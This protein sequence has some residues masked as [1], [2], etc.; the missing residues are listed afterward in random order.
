MR[1]SRQDRTR[2]RRVVGAVSA[3]GA[4]MLA[5][6][7]STPPGSRLFYATTLGAAGT[8]TIGGFASGPLH[9]GWTSGHGGSGHGASLHRPVVTPV[10]TG[11]AA[12]GCFYAGALVVR[13]VPLLDRALRNVLRFAEEGAQPLV[14]LT[15][16]ANGVAEEVFFRGAVYAA[17]GERH[18]VASSTALYTV[19]TAAT[20]NPALVLAAA[21]MGTLF[22]L[23][24]RASGG[25]QAPI[26]THLTWA[27]LMVRYLPTVIRVSPTPA[28]AV[29]K[30]LR[31]RPRFERL[32]PARVE[33]ETR[34][35]RSRR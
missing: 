3:A 9:R 1:P 20:R 4:G 27:T 18:P 24:R 22:G 31:R 34:A 12:F 29:T 26:L 14:L 28:A 19:A 6:S 35:P 32:R 30:V 23:Q 10:L 17:V 8:W 11:T 13:Q 7:F 2:R 33:A 21:V 25:I 15:T 16:L 5:A